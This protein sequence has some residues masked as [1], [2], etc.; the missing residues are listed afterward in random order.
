MAKKSLKQAASNTVKEEEKKK[1]VSTPATQ[2]SSPAEPST[3]NQKSKTPP[4][5]MNAGVER[6]N[7][8]NEISQQTKK[9]GIGERVD[10]RKPVL[11]NREKKEA[12]R[13]N[14]AAHANAQY[15]SNKLGR[16]LPSLEDYA[17]PSDYDPFPVE[18]GY[19]EDQAAKTRQ[20]AKDTANALK[21]TS[22]FGAWASI[23]PFTP[24]YQEIMKKQEEE[25][26]LRKAQKEGRTS[27][28]YEGRGNEKISNDINLFGKKVELPELFKDAS[29]NNWLAQQFKKVAEGFNRLENNATRTG[30]ID[31]S[32]LEDYSD[33]DL[34]KALGDYSV[35]NSYLQGTLENPH[36]AS[37]YD[38]FNAIWN[39]IN[40]RTGR[41]EKK[42]REY[43]RLVEQTANLSKETKDKWGV[44]MGIASRIGSLPDWVQMQINKQTGK[45]LMSGFEDTLSGVDKANAINQG[46]T[47]DMN[48]LNK[49]LY[50]LDTSMGSSALSMPL[51]YG[52]MGLMGMG[53][54]AETTQD[55]LNRGVSANDALRLGN[56]AGATETATEIFELESLLSAFESGSSKNIKDVLGNMLK[57]TINEGTSE[58]VGTA[59]ERVSDKLIAKEK[60]IYDLDK[61]AFMAN[62]M[63]EEEASKAAFNNVIQDIDQSIAMGGISGGIF[64][65][66]GSSVD[67]FNNQRI[68]N[69]I[70]AQQ[71]QHLME[72]VYRRSPMSS[73]EYIDFLQPNQAPNYEEVI[74]SL[75]SGKTT[76]TDV[77]D[78]TNYLEGGESQNLLP[79]LQK[80]TYEAKDKS[81]K[82]L[83][84]ASNS[85]AQTVRQ[86][87]GDSEK[88]S[89]LFTAL[90]DYAQTGNTQAR[91][92]AQNLAKELDS[93]LSGKVY[94]RGKASYNYADG[95]L[96]SSFDNAVNQIDSN[97]RYSQYSNQ[98]IN[99][100][101]ETVSTLRNEANNAL[102]P[103]VANANLDNFI[104]SANEVMQTGSNES[105]QRF[106]DSANNLA[107]SDAKFRSNENGVREQIFKVIDEVDNATKPIRAQAES[108]P[109]DTITGTLPINNEQ[110]EAQEY[111]PLPSELLQQAKEAEESP[112]EEYTSQALTNTANHS[113]IA[114]LVNK[115]KDSLRTLKD[116]K[117]DGLDEKLGRVNKV[118]EVDSLK[119]ASENL[120]ENLENVDTET[121]RILNLAD[122]EFSGVD[123][124]E[125]MMIMEYLLDQ[126]DVPTSTR[127]LKLIVE[128]SHNAGQTLQALAKYT[129]SAMG[130]LAKGQSLV[131]QKVRQYSEKH[132]GEV[133]KSEEVAKELTAINPTL[134]RAF[135]EMGNDGSKMPKL[136]K[137]YNQLRQEVVN[138][139]NK[140]FASVSSKFSDADIDFLTRMIQQGAT[141]KELSN[142]LMTKAATGSFGITE[143]DMATVKELFDKA[144][145]KGLDSKEGSEFLAQA[146]SLMA[147]KMG[148]EGTFMDKWNSWRYLAMLGNTRTHFRNILG[149]LL[150]GTTTRVKDT[151][152]ATMEAGYQ[153]LGGDIQRTKAV[154][155]YANENDRALVNGAK[156]YFD[157]NAY[158]PAT[159][160]G[161][162]YN[163]ISSEIMRQRKIWKDAGLEKYIGMLDELNNRLL[164]GEDNFAIKQKYKTALA[165]YLKANKK[166]ADIF[167]ST[168]EADIEFLKKA[169]DYAVQQA[170]IA[171]FHEDNA[172]ADFLNNIERAASESKNPLVRVG[173]QAII[174]GLVPFKKTPANI[175]KQGLKYSPV[176]AMGTV[177]KAIQNFN[178]SKNGNEFSY[179]AADFINDIA[180][181]L[182]GSAIMAL[183]AWLC[184]KGILRP[185]SDDDDKALDEQSY[186]LNWTSPSGKK[187]SYTIDWT[188]PSGMPLF[189]GA[190]LYNSFQK[191]G[192]IDALGSVLSASSP[193]IE[194]SMLQGIRDFFKSSARIITQD[195]EKGTVPAIGTNMALNYVGQGVPTAMGHIARAVDE[196]RRS[197]YVPEQGAVG[198]A[199]KW[200]MKQMNKLPGLSFLN[201]PYINRWGEEEQQPGGNFLGRL[202]YNMFSPGYLNET[203]RNPL[204]AELERLGDATGESVIPKYAKYNPMGERLDP[205]EYTDYAESLGTNRTDMLYDLINSEAYKNAD[206]DTK[207]KYVEEISKFADAIAKDE[208]F[209]DYDIAS[210]NKGDYEAYREGGTR[211]LIDKM[212]RDQAFK[213]ANVSHSQFLDE[214]YEQGP[215]AFAEAVAQKKTLE[216]YGLNATEK[217]IELLESQGEAG[218][219]N[220]VTIDSLIKD[221][222]ITSSNAKAYALDVGAEEAQ[223]TFEDISS[224]GL[225]PNTQNLGIYEKSGT[226]YLPVLKKADAAG[227]DNGTL[228]KAELV[229]YLQSQG[230]SIAEANRIIELFGWKKI[231]KY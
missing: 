34:Y 127:M 219:Q 229:S 134:N 20:K 135:A 131:D 157:K 187:F 228:K 99:G 190:E 138:T 74:D 92:Y 77:D 123:M 60:S 209:Y 72:D 195:P 150:F 227:D 87:S 183:G 93:E 73:E 210:K 128:K 171:T 125:S 114:G 13:I 10:G 188:A 199:K 152:A 162:K 57:Q 35:G 37:D 204:T 50:G 149:N 223:K 6:A 137:S 103:K 98:T 220:K 140:E 59:I 211:G 25:S 80:P 216:E 2:K 102:D 79:E 129:R 67:Y 111:G 8:K 17:R 212:A 121:E 181:Q 118:R 117:N 167:N 56:I 41:S 32:R 222:G 82:G 97:R 96:L 144:E 168:N 78:Y 163:D 165:S 65:G 112:T 44:P 151:L 21:N 120:G 28:K 192:E 83:K 147:E 107:N 148:P 202:A 169:S 89:R 71:Q 85:I 122:K 116:A 158:V 63:S 174:E 33:A 52:G 62:G 54:A 26:E 177:A 161:S 16:K 207:K 191:D 42:D 154:L 159:E 180:E 43:N 110:N 3:V 197:T 108:I 14:R 213:D 160:G 40:K 75:G 95:K 185:S 18:Y 53:S 94:K 186:S 88:A 76:Q 218:L 203:T 230:Y 91:D 184:S 64:G 58:G 66:F 27:L 30:G 166:T 9:A 101:D 5:A 69:A 226:Q 39:E 217:N 55:A 130:I 48:E 106:M 198:E 115:Y 68:D 105:W 193:V 173:G 119:R 29:E 45:P 23:R 153:A 31:L 221:Y 146:Y 70:K 136:E 182:T 124:D 12:A 200:L 51:G 208:N 90:N 100:M 164:T 109:E 176:G 84:N 132:Q 113:F 133:K 196:T 49:M 1:K 61:Q 81:I 170:K 36:V 46:L 194:M 139:L 142:L 224:F 22:A 19:K 175:L 205:E 15:E 215:E 145:E 126:G 4:G 206:D 214:A 178:D 143:A 225:T 7:I 231:K 189:V 141:P 156:D 11:S 38:T 179:H 86:Y 172:V 47:Q 201:E 24:E 104:S 155:N